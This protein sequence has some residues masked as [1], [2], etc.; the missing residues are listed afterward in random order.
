MK[1]EGTVNHMA[2]QVRIILVVPLI[3]HTEQ[4]KVRYYAKINRTGRLHNKHKDERT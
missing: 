1:M 4:I 2:I 3:K